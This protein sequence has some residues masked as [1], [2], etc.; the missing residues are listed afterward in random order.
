MNPATVQIHADW[1]IALAADFESA[2]FDD[3]AA[4][5][6]TMKQEGKEIYPPGKAIF[7]A[8]NLVPPGN[9]KAVIIGQDPYHN[10]GEAMGL[11]FSVPR[12][13]NVPPSLKNIY[14]ELHSD[15]GMKIPSHGDLTSWANEGVLLLNAILT[16]EKN[17]AASHRNLGWQKFTDRTIEYLSDQF[18]GIVFMLWGNFA[19]GKKSLIDPS[20][21]LVLESAHPSPLAGNA[22][23]GCKHFSKANEYLVKMNK[24]QIDWHIP[25]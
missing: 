11:S 1:Q 9:V 12:G 23:Q 13:V 17:Q 16:V 2:W 18:T 15:I 19:K 25:E 24:K 7:Q 20:R 5:L 22:F 21:H 8:Y 6:R 10:P 14:K 3:L 4:S